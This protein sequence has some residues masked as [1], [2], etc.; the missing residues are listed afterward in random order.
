V[1]AAEALIGRDEFGMN[2]ITAERA[3]RLDV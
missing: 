2:Y 1:L 3:G